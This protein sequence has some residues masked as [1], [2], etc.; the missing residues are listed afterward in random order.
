MFGNQSFVLVER[1][2]LTNATA[3]ECLTRQGGTVK[4][5]PGIKRKRLELPSPVPSDNGFGFTA[6]PTGVS[7]ESPGHDSRHRPYR[8]KT[9]SLKAPR[10]VRCCP[11]AQELFPPARSNTAN[12]QHSC[13]WLEP[14]ARAASQTKALS[15]T[16]IFVSRSSRSKSP[17]HRMALAV[18][19]LRFSA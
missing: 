4:A 16:G 3:A 14:R 2:T 18:T 11:T 10:K 19:I 5:H 15:P 6:V 1:I 9:R 13:W 8:G 7:G 12:P 17:S